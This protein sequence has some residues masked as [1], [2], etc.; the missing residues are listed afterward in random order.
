MKNIAV[1]LVALAMFVV[2]CVSCGTKNPEQG[3]LAIYAKHNPHE[4]IHG[5]VCVDKKIAGSST[6]VVFNKPISYPDIDDEMV[7]HL[8]V[9]F[10]KT[11]GDFS[12]Q[13]SVA[14]ET[15]KKKTFL[16]RYSELVKIDPNPQELIEGVADY[17]ALSAKQN[18]NKAMNADK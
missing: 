10:I 9:H 6:H 12:V 4:D 11:D 1:L 7:R 15:G 18:A 16:G 3:L 2:L 14:F 8:Y 17:L 5:Y 13:Y